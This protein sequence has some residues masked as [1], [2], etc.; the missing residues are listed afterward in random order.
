MQPNIFMWGGLLKSL[1]DS[2]LHI[3]RDDV[4]STKNARFNRN[5]IKGNG[6]TK[7][8]TIPY[9]SFKDSNLI[10]EQYLNTSDKIVKKL[11][12]EFSK[13][14]SDFPYH[15]V[16]LRLL[17]NTLNHKNELTPIIEVYMKFLDGLREIGFPLCEVKLASSLMISNNPK[18]YGLEMVNKILDTTKATTYLAA[19]NTIKYA[20]PEDYSVKYV[21]LQKYRDLSYKSKNEEIFKINFIENLSCL[22]IISCLTLDEILIHLEKSNNWEMFEN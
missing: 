19:E 7:W 22:D 11:I 18:L 4:K 5:K 8:F 16:T 17:Q 21:M 13:R 20:K 14:Y 1:L 15:K 2:D 12:S 9:V 6:D 10:R 3:I